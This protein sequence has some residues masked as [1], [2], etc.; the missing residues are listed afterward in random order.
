M[1]Y[2][3]APVSV[4]DPRTLLRHLPWFFL[5]LLVSAER[6]GRV[7]EHGPARGARVLELLVV[8]Q[9]YGNHNSGAIEFGPDGN[10]Y[11][12]TGD[13]TPPN[14]DP[15]WQGYAPLDWR[16]GRSY[17][18]AA[19]SSGNTNDLR[20]KLLRIRPSAGGGYTIPAG[21]LYPQGTAQTRPE[22][23][24]MGFR[25]PF[26]FS[27]DP[28]NGWVYLADYGPDRNPPTTN[29]GPEGLVEL[30]VIKA[31]GNY[32]WPFCHGDNQPYAPY[33]PST[34]VVGA[35]FNCNAP[36]NNS[37][38]NTGLTDLPPAIPAKAPERVITS[39]MATTTL[40]PP[41]LAACGFAPT[42]L[43][44]NPQVVL[45]NSQWTTQAIANATRN[46]TCRRRPEAPSTGSQP[47]IWGRRALGST[48]CEIGSNLPSAWIPGSF[49]T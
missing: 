6:R 36:V 7:H 12:G 26:R 35:K 37:P 3:T 46:P 5:L 29:R 20:G 44:S 25:N 31:A 48:G 30:N 4:E 19:R 43:N 28:A 49:R 33:N 9:P 41:Y 8:E 15:A 38:N 14:L 18:D 2:A 17:L 13:D 39:T 42:A 11:I 40:I 45:N 24:A 47:R 10:L 23:Y 27:I 32:G 21:N 22:V 1:P 34:G 16:S